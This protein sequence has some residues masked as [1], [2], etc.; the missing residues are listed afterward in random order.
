MKTVSARG[1]M[2][3]GLKRR[4]FVR[5]GAPRDDSVFVFCV[6]GQTPLPHRNLKS[7]GPSIA[8]GA[9]KSPLIKKSTRPLEIEAVG[10]PVSVEDG[11]VK[12][13]RRAAPL[14]LLTA[15]WNNPVGIQK[16]IEI[17]GNWR[18][19]AGKLSY[20]SWRRCKCK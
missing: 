12:S 9:G 4:S 13:G 7:N 10:L 18:R 16:I 20:R 2:E 1:G 11:L 5:K 14:L 3:V 15:S 6:D 19:R 8:P 17:T